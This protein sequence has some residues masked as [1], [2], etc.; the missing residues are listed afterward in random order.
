MKLQ[1]SNHFTLEKTFIIAPCSVTGINWQMQ[2]RIG[3]KWPKMAKNG[4]FGQY[5]FDHFCLHQKNRILSFEIIKGNHYGHFR[6]IFRKCISLP[7]KRALFLHYAYD[8]FGS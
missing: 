4:H 6:T 2:A 1:E 8:R 5:F 7:S 3:Q